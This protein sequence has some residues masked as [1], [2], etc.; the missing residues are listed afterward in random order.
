MSPME[1][2]KVQAPRDMPNAEVI[3][4]DQFIEYV[5]DGALR[6]TPKQYVCL[7]PAATLLDERGEA[8]RWELEDLPVSM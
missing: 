4:S 6:R 2:V 1:K 7:K 8:M 5:L 3:L